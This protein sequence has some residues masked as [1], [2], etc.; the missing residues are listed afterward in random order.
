MFRPGEVLTVV[1]NEDGAVTQ[2]HNMQVVAFDDG[3]LRVQQF[4]NTIV[5][6]TR[7]PSFVKAT[8]QK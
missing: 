8:V 6:N 2:H 7:S 3:L 4:E 5:I 1:L